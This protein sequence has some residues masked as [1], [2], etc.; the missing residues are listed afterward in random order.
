MIA[1]SSLDALTRAPLWFL[2]SSWP[3]RSL[4]YLAASLL[5]AGAIAGLVVLG[6]AADVGRG[7]AAVGF[8]LLLLCA[9]L[10]AAF[11]RRRIRL[12]DLEPLPRPTAKLA[13]RLRGPDVWRELAHALVAGLALWWSD[14][15]L[16]VMSLGI[17][18]MLLTAPWQPNGTDPVASAVLFA[19]GLL[20]LPVAAYPI[21]AWA[22]AR[23]AITRVIASPRDELVEVRRSRARMADAFEVERRR[24]ER[25]LHDGAQQRLVALTMKLGLAK[26]TV[27]PGS[28]AEKE[29]EGAH[30]QA[31]L[32]LAELREL[33]RGVHP[34]VLSGR[35]LA[36][37]VRDAAGRSPIAVEVDFDVPRLR[38]QIEV[39]AYYVV[40]EALAN[41]AKHSNARRAWVTGRVTR[42]RLRLEVGDDGVGG[43]HD[44]PGGGLAGLADR[45]ATV[46]G[47][48]YL[49]S[50]AGGPTVVRADMPALVDVPAQDVSAQDVSGRA[51]E[52]A[53]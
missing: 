40:A 42:G 31:R 30:E 15:G 36:A 32:A 45:V 13:E 26:L 50:P 2:R 48:L 10:V 28:A 38:A 51:E 24:L 37:A 34:Q 7:T 5:P 39:N 1:R 35:G 17:P 21:T 33:I 22:G 23:A 8:F 27:E 43:A 44:R 53:A 11:E 41:L 19:A 6:Q 12:V 4:G 9:P 14:L 47:R 25:D 3:W 49:S 46:D 29:L 16:V 52:A 18:G 20:L